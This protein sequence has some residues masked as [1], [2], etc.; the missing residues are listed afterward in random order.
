[1]IKGG[2]DG[3]K[4][5]YLYAYIVKCLMFKKNCDGP[6]KV[7]PFHNQ[8]QKLWVHPQLIN[9][10]DEYTPIPTCALEIKELSLM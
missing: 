9:K 10:K 5:N 1:M 4:G 8:K 6:M 2:G 7:A 3:A